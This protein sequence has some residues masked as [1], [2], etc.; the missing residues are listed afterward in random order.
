MGKGCAGVLP[1]EGDVLGVLVQL[2]GTA[3]ASKRLLLFAWQPWG[4]E[5]L[6]IH[7]CFPAVPGA[8]TPL[9]SRLCW[10]CAEYLLTP[11][12]CVWKRAEDFLL[13]PG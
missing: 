3:C 5:N 12:S 2:Q 11:L 7:L 10:L 4:K 13:I 8:G 1:R 6:Q 9:Q